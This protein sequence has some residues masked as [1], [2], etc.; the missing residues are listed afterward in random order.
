LKLTNLHCCSKL[1]S[2]QFLAARERDK[3]RGRFNYKEA[4]H[5]TG[6]N[7]K[8][9]ERERERVVAVSLFICP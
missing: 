8:C 9:R 6:K 2:L 1:V 5:L 4:R 3:E 7:N